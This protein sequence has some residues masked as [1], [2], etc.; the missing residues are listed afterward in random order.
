MDNRIPNICILNNDQRTANKLRQYLKR[1]FG[2]LLNI[3]LVLTGHKCIT[4]LQNEVDMVVIDDY[5][6]EKDPKGMFGLQLLKRIRSKNPMTNVVILT[7]SADISLAVE[8]MK[9][10]AKDYIFNKRGAWERLQN[11]IRC[12]F[13]SLNVVAAKGQTG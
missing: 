3:S 2:D 11:D 5:L 12:L 10:G 7:S 13:P 4:M 8:A 1:R 9:F 6:Y